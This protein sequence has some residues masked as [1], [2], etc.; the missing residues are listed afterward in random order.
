MIKAQGQITSS[1]RFFLIHREGAREVGGY[2]IKYVQS[3][4]FDHQGF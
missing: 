2:H 1:H 3:V 4:Y